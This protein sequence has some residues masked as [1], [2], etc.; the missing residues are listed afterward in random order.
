MVTRTWARP[1]VM[2]VDAT[3]GKGLAENLMHSRLSVTVFGV[4]RAWKGRFGSRCLREA[5]A[6]RSRTHLGGGAG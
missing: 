4:P 5:A 1:P 3:S 6:T 2:C